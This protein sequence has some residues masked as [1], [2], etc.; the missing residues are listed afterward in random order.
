MPAK[1]IHYLILVCLLF[2][3]PIV[4]VNSTPSNTPDSSSVWHVLT[5]GKIHPNLRYFYMNTDNV[6][7]SYDAFAHGIGMGISYESAPWKHFSLGVSGQ[8]IHMVNTSSLVPDPKFP[9]LNRY[10]IGLVDLI[11]PQSKALLSRLEKLYVSYSI[12]KSSIKMGRQV[13]N[14]PF[15]NP[16]DGRMRPTAVSGIWVDWN[17]ITNTKVEGGYIQAISPRSTT[18]WFGIGESMG[19]YPQGLNPDG[20]KSN[21]LGNI[22]SQGIGMIG[23]TLKQW[24]PWSIQV[25]NMYVDQ[26]MYTGMLQADAQWP[27][28]QKSQWIAGVQYI[29]QHAI[30]DG[31]NP[32]P[33]KTYMN[34]GA[35]SR[36]F[37]AKF[38]WEN[39]QWKSSINYNRITGEGRYLMPREWGKDPFFTFMPRER[40]EGFGDVAALVAKVA[41]QWKKTPLKAQLAQGYF[42][43]PPLNEVALNKYAMPSYSQSNIEV[44]FEPKGKWKGSS[45]SLIYVQKIGL[46]N[47]IL[48]DKF[49]INKVNMSQVNFIVNYNL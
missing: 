31:G 4:P 40:N 18:Q 43:L 26:V 48:A 41:Y 3:L 11:H 44:T 30:Q 12:Q 5:K 19:I 8:W 7:S 25:W 32:D 17:N 36:T 24:K 38:G 13:I 34:P 49:I 47:H 35:M 10:E 23:I 2:V 20:S 16:Q 21:Y 6:G 1:N 39:K 28:N 9:I 27:T 37:G 29:E 45:F 33:S 42:H 15:I 46:E 14:T 22:K